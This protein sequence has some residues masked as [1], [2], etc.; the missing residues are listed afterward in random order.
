MRVCVQV[1]DGDLRSEG[2][3]CG[4]RWVKKG[5]CSVQGLKSEDFY[6][7]IAWSLLN[8]K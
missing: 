2:G 3:G 1:E 6:L 4:F 7:T 5:L 8:E